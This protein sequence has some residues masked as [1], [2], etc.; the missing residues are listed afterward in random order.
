MKNKQMDNAI[1]QFNRYCE[2]KAKEQ[3]LTI[4]EY[5]DHLFDKLPKVNPC[6]CEEYLKTQL[7][8]SKQ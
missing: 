7:N 6:E 8:I 1:E 2:E 4:S 5:K 3:G